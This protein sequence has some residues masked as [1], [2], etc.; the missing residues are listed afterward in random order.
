MSEITAGKWI[1]E[2]A[3]FLTGSTGASQSAR[4]TAAINL[5][6]IPGGTPMRHFTFWLLASAV[7]PALLS[8]QGNRAA[9]PS[10]PVRIV[11]GPEFLVSRDGDVAHTETMIAANPRDPKNL[12]G[13]SIVGGRPG[14]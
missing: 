12:I 13:G 14:G 5:P 1:E 3:S 8:A 4:C 9:V 11:V 2:G 6:R 7:V 10:R